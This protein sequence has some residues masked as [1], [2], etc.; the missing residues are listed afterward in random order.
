M[1]VDLPR[2]SNWYGR[3][4]GRGSMAAVVDWYRPDYRQL[5]LDKG[6]DIREI[7]EELEI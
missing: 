5:L 1:W 3:L 7:I 6:R 4:V 2:V